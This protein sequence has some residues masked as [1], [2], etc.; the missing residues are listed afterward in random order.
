M[1]KS[2]HMIIWEN[3]F[4]GVAAATDAFG[5]PIE[6]KKFNMDEEGGWYIDIILQPEA[7]SK[8]KEKFIN[9]SNLQPLSLKNCKKKYK[10]HSGI[11]NGKKFQVINR[12]NRNYVGIM[13]VD[14]KEAYLYDRWQ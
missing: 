3:C 14:E 11:I 12:P 5:D 8:Q 7:N 1:K 9:L 10:K 2:P 4:G 6:F 13:L